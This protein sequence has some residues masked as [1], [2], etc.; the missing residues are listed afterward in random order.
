MWFDLPLYAVQRSGSGRW[1][2]RTLCNDSFTPAAR[3]VAVLQE[4]DYP[5]VEEQRGAEVIRLQ[6]PP[7][8]TRGEI[9]NLD[10]RSDL[11]ELARLLDH[12]APDFHD[13]ELFHVQKN[14]LAAELRRLARWVAPRC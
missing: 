1:L 12:L 2:L 8:R 9:N 14:A 4:P 5:T 11:L 3:C 6:Q 7:T 10:F 13:P